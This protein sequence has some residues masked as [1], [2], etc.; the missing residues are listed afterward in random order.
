MI[1]KENIWIAVKLVLILGTA[2]AAYYANVEPEESLPVEI[3]IFPVLFFGFGLPRFLK[4]F[5]TTRN[6][7]TR[8]Q[9]WRACPFFFGAGPLPFYHLGGGMCVVGG[10]VGLLHALF[11]GLDVGTPIVEMSMGLGCLWGVR[12]TVKSVE[13]TRLQELL[14]QEGVQEAA[15]S[16]QDAQKPTVRKRRFNPANVLLGL[17]VFAV[18]LVILG[19]LAVPCSIC[20]VSAMRMVK[21]EGDIDQLVAAV[22]TYR[23]EYGELP[24]SVDDLT[25]SRVMTRALTTDPWENLYKWQTSNSGLQVQQFDD[26]GKPTDV[27]PAPSD[28]EIYIYSFGANGVDENGGGD[29]ISSWDDRKSYEGHK[30]YRR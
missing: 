29:D 24:G 19:I 7:T 14:R 18:V 25:S 15:V 9:I 5:D 20:R 13:K 12:R 6:Y 28:K 1:T 30:S 26:R 2:V 27:L 11:T 22:Q 3:A 10:L 21:T 8:I 17:T 4:G 23:S 16:D